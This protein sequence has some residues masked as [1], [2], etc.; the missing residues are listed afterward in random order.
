MKKKVGMKLRAG[1]ST[2]HGCIVRKRHR[3]YSNSREKRRRNYRE[4]KKKER[5]NE[6]TSSFTYV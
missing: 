4:R 1:W 3:K 6:L 5:Y 2:R